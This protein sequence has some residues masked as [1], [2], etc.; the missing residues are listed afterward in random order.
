MKSLMKSGILLAGLISLAG[1][2]TGA[3]IYEIR[4]CKPATQAGTLQYVQA[5]AYTTISE[6]LKAGEDLYFVMRLVRNGINNPHWR[7]VHNDVTWGSPTLDEA[8]YPLQI[9]I[10][11]SGELRWADLVETQFLTPVNPDEPDDGYIYSDFVFK[12][13]TKPGDFA[14]PIK[15]A[16]EDE[17]GN[18]MPAQESGS[19]SKYVF[20][21]LSTKV[22]DQGKWQIRDGN[23]DSAGANDSKFADLVFASN[24]DNVLDQKPWGRRETDFTL[25]KCGFYVQTVDFH[26]EWEIPPTDDSEGVWRTVHE[27]STKIGY[28]T[29]SLVADSAVEEDNITLYVWSTD[30]KAVKISGGTPTTIVTN[31]VAGAGGQLEKQTMTVQ[32]AKVTISRGSTTGGF[33]LYGVAHPNKA[34]LVLSAYPYYT[35]DTNNNRVE[36]YLEVPVMCSEKESASVYLEIDPVEV[37]ADGDLE[38]SKSMVAVYLNQ[39]VDTTIHVTLTPSFNATNGVADADIKWEDYF[40]FASDESVATTPT[41]EESEQA[42]TLEFTANSTA[43]QYVYIYPLKSDEYTRT[44]AKPIRLTPS[45][46]AGEQEASGIKNLNAASF[47]IKAAKPVITGVEHE[48]SVE[49]GAS[50]PL[51]ITLSDIFADITDEENGY[52]LKINGSTLPGKYFYKEEK[53]VAIDD[54]G[55]VTLPSVSYSTS[56]E[57]TGTIQVLSPYGKQWSEIYTFNVTVKDVT[58]IVIQTIDGKDNTYNEGDSVNFQIGFFSGDEQIKLGQDAYAFLYSEDEIDLKQFDE[59]FIITNLQTAAAGTSGIKIGKNVT[60]WVSN[61]ML[62]LDG[63]NIAK[64]GAKFRFQVVL[65]T[66]KSWNPDNKIEGYP[67]SEELN[68]RVYNV[69]PVIRG[70]YVND[71]ADAYED[72]STYPTK[73]PVGMTRRFRPFVD[74]PGEFDLTTTDTNEQFRVQWSVYLD[75]ELYE[76]DPFIIQGN[77][78]GDNPTNFYYTFT[79]AGV[80]TFRC[81]VKDKDMSRYTDQSSSVSVEVLNQPYVMVTGPEGSTAEVDETLLDEND[82]RGARF[83]VSLDYFDNRYAGDV[84]VKLEVV[85]YGEGNRPNPG[86]LL[87]DSAF[88]STEPGEEEG[89]YYVTLS[90]TKKTQV[91]NAIELDGTD[92]AEIFGFEIKASVVTENL[93]PT[94]NEKANDY[95]LPSSHRVYIKNVAPVVSVTPEENTNHWEVAGGAATGHPISW[96]IMSDVMDDFTNKWADGTQGGIKVTFTGCAN[97]FSTNITGAASG[98]FVPNFGAAAGEQSVTLM[99]EDKDGG[100][101]SYTWLFKVTPSKFLITTATGPFGGDSTSQ[102]SQKYALAK[103][104]GKGHTYVSGASFTSAENFQL[105]WNCGKQITMTVYGFGYKDGD[106]DNGALSNGLDQQIDGSGNNTDPTVNIADDS[107][108]K[109]D[110]EGYDSFFY[111]WLAQ[112]KNDNTG[113]GGSTVLNGAILPERPG[114]VS[115]GR[116]TLPTEYTGDGSYLDTHIEAIFAREWRAADNLGD[117]NQDGIPDVFVHRTWGGGKLLELLGLS[118]IENDL[119]DIAA[120]NPDEDLMPGVYMANGTL[121][122][123]DGIMRSYAPIGNVALTTFREIRGLDGLGLN[124]TDL[125]SSD[126]EFSPVET[127]AY[128]ATVHSKTPDEVAEEL[129]KPVDEREA[130]A[131][132]T[133]EDLEKWS[134]EPTGEQSRLDPTKAD[135]DSDGFDDGWEYFFWYAAKV[136]VPGGA[137]KVQ[138]G[139]KYPFERFNHLRLVT[140]DEI[141]ASLVVE[142]FNPCSR[143]VDEAAEKT[144][145]FDNDGL[146]DIEELIIGTNPCHWDTDGDH[147]CDGWEVMMSLDPLAN[148]KNTNEDGDFMAYEHFQRLAYIDPST[149]IMYFDCDNQLVAGEDYK[150]EPVYNDKMEVISNIYY[151]IKADG[152]QLKRAVVSLTTTVDGGNP[153]PLKYGREDDYDPQN[154]TIFGA[155]L[156]YPQERDGILIPAGAP[157]YLDR[158]VFLHDQ[159]YTRYGFDPRTAWYMND[160]GLVGAR[161]EPISDSDIAGMAMRTKEYTTYDEYLLARYRQHFN[162]MYPGM[163][164]PPDPENT[165]GWLGLMTTIPTVTLEEEVT[166][167]EIIDTTGTNVTTNVSSNATTQAGQNQTDNKTDAE[168]SNALA[169]AL[170]AAN[171]G[172]NVVRAHGADSD[173]DGVPDGWELYVYRNPRQ[174]PGDEE[175][176]TA[177]E[178]P[179]LG[180]MLPLDRDDDGLVYAAEF[181]GTDSCNA[182]SGCQSIYSRHPGNTKGWFNKFF[183]TDPNQPDTDRDSIADGQEGND[184]LGEGGVEMRAFIFGTPTDD[185]SRCIRGGGLNPLTVDTDQDALPDPWERQYA[186]SPTDLSTGAPSNTVSIADGVAGK[187]LNVVYLAGGMDGTWYGDTYTDPVEE[188]V[189][190]DQW[191]AHSFDPLLGTVRDV[192]F[193]HDGLEN[194]QEYL[195]QTVRHFR[196]DDCT[197]LLMGRMLKEGP[198]GA[199]H[200]QGFMGYAPMSHSGSGYGVN[201]AAYVY[202]P[203]GVEVVVTTNGIAVTTNELTNVMVTNYVT[204]V[205]SNVSSKATAVLERMNAAGVFSQ[206]WSEM[207]WKFCGYMS[208]PECAWDRSYTEPTL[209]AKEILLP[210]IATPDN[211]SDIYLMPSYLSY[212]STDPRN[213]DTDGDGMDDYYEMFHGLNPLLGSVQAGSKDVIAEA[214]GRAELFNAAF[215]EWTHTDY[216]RSKIF[217]DPPQNGSAV[218]PTPITLPLIYDWMMYPWFAGALEADPDGDGINNYEEMLKANLTSPN[219]THTDPTPRWFTDSGMPMSFTAQYYTQGAPVRNVMFPDS[220]LPFKLTSLATSDE[221]YQNAIMGSMREDPAAPQ[222]AFLTS[223]EENEGY[224]TDND[225]VADGREIIKTVKVATDPLDFSDP[226]RHQAAW[227]DGTDSFMMTRTQAYR[228]SDANDMFKQF[229]VEAW[230]CPERKGIVQTILDRAVLYSGNTAVNPG[231]VIRSNFRLGIDEQGRVFGLFDNADALESGSNEPVSC[232]RVTGQMLELGKWVHIALTYN[233]KKLTLYVNGQIADSAETTLIPANGVV[234]VEQDIGSGL[235]TGLYDF[236][237]TTL[238]LGARPIHTPSLENRGDPLVVDKVS[239]NTIREYFG[240]YIDEVRVWDGARTSAEILG[241][242][243]KRFTMADAKDNRISAYQVWLNRGTRN[244]NDGLPMLPPELLMHYSFTSLPGATDPAW[245]SKTPSGFNKQILDI[246]EV[247]YTKMQDMDFTGCYD[248]ARPELPNLVEVSCNLKGGAYGT[249]KLGEKTALSYGWWNECETK[250]RVYNDITVVPWVENTVAHLPAM[251]SSTMDSLYYS[252]ALAASY[253]DPTD[254]GVERFI[255]PNAANPYSFFNYGADRYLTLFRRNRLVEQMGTKYE[256]ILNLYRYEVRSRL[257]GPSDLLPMGGAYARRAKEM[258]DGVPADAW[259]YTAADDNA[260]GISDWWEEY[261]RGNYGNIT[262]DQDINWN[263]LIIYHGAEMPAY[264]AFLIDLAMGLQ[265]NGQ[266]DSDFVSTADTNANNLPDWW[267]DLFGTKGGADDDDDNDGLSNYNEYL[268]SFGSSPYGIKNGFPILNPLK[269]RTGRD[270][271]VTDYYLS[272]PDHAI[273]LSDRHISP[274]SYIGQIVS[275]TDFVENW[276]EKKYNYSFASSKKYDPDYDKDEDGWSNW[277]EARAF[278][279]RGSFAADVVDRFIDGDN[280]IICYPEPAIGVRLSYNG[281]QDT[282]S[283]GLVVRTFSGYTPRV[284]ATFTVPAYGVARSKIIG[285]YYADNVIR[286]FLTPGNLIPA[287]VRFERASMSAERTYRWH[288]VDGLGERFEYSGTYEEYRRQLLFNPALILDDI[289]LE[290]VEF[291]KTL[292]DADGNKGDIVFAGTDSAGNSVSVNIG[293]INYRTGEYSIDL[294]AVESATGESFEGN[295][296]QVIWSYRIGNEYPQAIWLSEPVS[297]RVKEG[298]NT[299]EAFIDMDGDGVFTPGIDPYGAVHDVEIGWHKTKELIIELKDESSAIARVNVADAQGAGNAAQGATQDEI[300][301]TVVVRRTSINGSTIFNDKTVPVRTLLT[302]TFVNDDRSYI[303]EADVISANTPD[304]D[305]KWLL[306]DAT[307]LGIAVE[308]L[309]TAGYEITKRSILTDGTVTNDVISTFENEFL[310]SRSIA[311]AKEPLATAPVYRAYPTMS[312]QTGDETMKAYRLQIATSTNKTDVIYDSGIKILPG[313]IGYTVGTLVHTVTPEFYWNCAVTTNGSYYVHDASNYYWRVAL[314]NSKF[315]TAEFDSDWSKWT[316]F[317]M[318]VSNVNRYPLLPTGYGKCG[319]VVRYFGCARTN[320]L[321]GAVVVEAFASADFTGMPLD[322]KRYTD[323]SRL[324]SIADITTTDVVLGGIEPGEVYLRA[325]IDLN[326]NGRRDAWEPWGYANRVGTDA[327]DIYT[328]DAIQVTD[329]VNAFEK[330]IIYIEDPDTNRNEIPDCTEAEFFSTSVTAEVVGNDSDGDGLSD[331]DE[332]SFGTDPSMWDSDGDGMPDGW[333]AIFADMDPLFADAGE[334]TDGDVMAFATMDAKLVTIKSNAPDAELVTYIMKTDDTLPV[335]GDLAKGLEVYN[336]FEYPV[337]EDGVEVKYIGRGGLITIDDPAPI[338]NIVDD[339]TN[340]VQYVNRVVNVYDAKVA[341]LHAQ[342]YAEFG[343]N[344]LTAVNATNAVNTK[345]F[346]ALDKYLLLRYFASLGICEEADVNQKNLWKSYSLVPYNVDYDEDGVPDGWELYVMFGKN[347]MNLESF[348]N[349]KA[350]SCWK[351]DDREIDEDADNLKLVNEYDRGNM[352]TDPWNDHTVSSVFNDSD[353]YFY[354][355][356]TPEAQFSDVDNDG[357]SNI[358][359]YKAREYGLVLDVRKLMTDTVT[360]DYFRQ[361]VVAGNTHYIGEVVA[362][363]DFIED[364]IESDFGYNRGLYDAT[365]DTDKDGWSNWSEIR[366]FVETGVSYIAD[367]ISNEVIRS[368]I[369]SEE[370]DYIRNNYAVLEDNIS[371]STSMD[372]AG[373]WTSSISGSIRYLD[374]QTVMRVQSNYAGVPYPTINVKLAYSG[375][376]DIDAGAFVIEA[377]ASANMQKKLCWWVVPQSDYEGSMAHNGYLSMSLKIPQHGYLKEGDIHFAA[378]ADINGDGMYN[379]AEPF[380]IVKSIPVG[381]SRAADFTIELTDV[382]PVVPRI[383]ILAATSDRTVLE[384]STTNTSNVVFGST[385]AAPVA[386]GAT[387][388]TAGG[389]TSSIDGEQ[390]RVRIVR[391]AINGDTTAKKRTLLNRIYTVA[392]RSF[393][394]EGDFYTALKNDID[395][396]LAAD[397][398]S[399][400]LAPSAIADATYEVILGDA[401]YKAG[402]T[403]ENVFATFKN[404]YPSTRSSG[405]PI[406][407]SANSRGVVT[408]ARP[409]FEFNADTQAYTAYALQVSRDENFGDVVF[410]TTNLLSGAVKGVVTAEP[411]FFAEDGATYFW[412]VA[413]FNAKFSSL[414]KLSSQDVVWSEAAKFTVDLSGEATANVKYY[415]PSATAGNIVVEAYS[416]PDFAGIAKSRVVGSSLVDGAASITLSGLPNG[417]YY[418]LAFIDRNGDGVRQSYESWGYACNVGT[419]DAEIWTPVSV[420]INADAVFDPAV[421]TVYIEDTDINQ[422]FIVDVLDN[423]D[424]LKAA[425]EAIS[426]ESDDDS[427]ND[428]SDRDGDGLKGFEEEEIGTD[429][430]SVDT[431]GDGMWDGWEVWAGTDPLDAE[432]ADTVVDGDVMAYSEVVMTTVRTRS[433][434]TGTEEIYVLPEGAA[435]PV[436]GDNMNDKV[437][438]KAFEYAGGMYGIGASVTIPSTAKYILAG[439]SNTTDNVVS[440]YLFTEDAAINVGDNVTGR[441]AYEIA[442]VDGGIYTLGTL[443]NLNVDV[444]IIE[445]TSSNVVSTVTA[446]DVTLGENRAIEVNTEAKV[447]LLHNQVYRKYGFNSKTANGYIASEDRINTKE[448]TALDKY[449]LIRY[450]EAMGLCDERVVNAAA[451]WASWSLKPGII[452]SDWGDSEGRYGDGLPDGWELYTGYSPWDFADRTT[453]DDSDSLPLYN[454]FDRGN[455]PSD[456]NTVD[457]D[458]DGVTDKHAFYYHLKGEDA[459]KDADGDGL[460]NYAEYLVSEVFNFVKLDPNNP[461]TDGSVVDYF[462]KVGEMYLGEMFTD[463]DRVGDDWEYQFAMAGVDGMLYANPGEYD[464]MIDRDNDGWSNYAEFRSN[465]DP[466]VDASSGIDGF[467]R[468][469]HPV[470]VIEMNLVYNGAENLAGSVTFKAWNEKAN[471]DMTKQPDA[472]WTVGNTVEMT[473]STQLGQTTATEVEPSTKYIGINPKVRKTYYL[474]PGVVQA[475]TFRLF[476]KDT[477]FVWVNPETLEATS[478]GLVEEAQWYYFVVDKEGK[479]VTLGGEFGGETEVGT[480]DYKTGKVTIDFA[481]PALNEL[482]LGDPE[483]AEQDENSS[484][485]NNN[486]TDYQSIRLGSAYVK[487]KWQSKSVSANTA[488]TYYLSD[489]DQGYAGIKEGFTTFTAEFTP[490]AGG[491][492]PSAGS[493]MGGIGGMGATATATKTVYGVVRN[494]EVGWQ[495]AKVTIELS[496]H[497][498]ITPRIDLAAGTSDRPDL[499]AEGYYTTDSRINTETNMLVEAA[500]S[501]QSTRVRVARHAINGYPCYKLWALPTI[502]MDKYFTTAARS[503]LTEADFLGNGQFDIDWAKFNAEVMNNKYVAD[504]FNYNALNITNVSY[505]VVIGEGK[506]SFESEDDMEEIAASKFLVTRRFDR[507]CATPQLD[508]VSQ[509]VYGARPTFKWSMPGESVWAKQFGSTYTAFRL[510]I[511]DSSDGLVW[512]SGICRAPQMNSVGQFVW[513]A[514]ICAGEKLANGKTFLTDSSYKWRVSM[515]NAKFSTESTTKWSSYSTFA[516]MVN[517]QQDVNDHGYSAIDVSVK[518]AGSSVVLAKY[519]GAGTNGTVRVQAFTTADFSGTPVAE[520]F[521]TND[522]ENIS[523]NTANAKLKGLPA[524]GDF[525][526]RAFIDMDGDGELSAFE[527]WGYAGEMVV[528]NNELVKSPIVGVWIEDSDTDGDWLP[529]A[530]E[531]ASAGWRGKWESVKEVKSQTSIGSDKVILPEGFVTITNKIASGVFDAAISAGLPGASLTVFQS[532]DF[533]AALIGLDVS[534]MSSISAIR[535]AIEKKIVPDTLKISSMTLDTAGKKVILGVDASV[536]DTIAGIKLRDIFGIES[537]KNY[538]T[539]TLK[540]YTKATLAEA[541]WT[542]KSEIT[543]NIGADEAVVEV[544]L[545][546]TLDC[547]SGYYK[548]EVVQ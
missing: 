449:L 469:E 33:K 381:Y 399:M 62:A 109:Y 461:K 242:Y 308:D 377:Y 374:T 91:I 47:T 405:L 318:D 131:T 358:Q 419:Q 141:P 307:K 291:G 94:P 316:A 49:S 135:T 11:V 349:G 278:I 343:F 39:P 464:P 192:D 103:G 259:E 250:S 54:E 275:D 115:S 158:Y 408:A 36:D 171:Q 17:D 48:D 500:I 300:T 328:P 179:I 96:K 156:C 529:D 384:G 254:S 309:R 181:A 277:A 119:T 64:N 93:L 127:N 360:N 396:Y 367:V 440:S 354:D 457:T 333:E 208:R 441:Q 92:N 263:T 352:P 102:L 410:A 222:Q 429:P 76:E 448:F 473:T 43:R 153:V 65:C 382:T 539:V 409:S 509:I 280:H 60:S 347:D 530:W 496:E 35:Y 10:Y 508:N 304:L 20:N 178:P 456:P 147:M 311:I 257:V 180:L 30:E 380:G 186:G 407:P 111:C 57:K 394:H 301:T 484:D 104:I 406:A 535:D 101:H 295:I 282:S 514:P 85:Q 348:T 453:D 538:A 41:K 518:Y 393:I 189:E 24:V 395:P 163:Q 403:N 206:P 491:N 154:P 13:T 485:R 443:T 362:D 108:Y 95:Y 59:S 129:A 519:K 288:Y 195:I 471:F 363:H 426:S 203:E 174:A 415:G 6:P 465:T 370:Y 285:G 359:E 167:D 266:F 474:G 184:L 247:D 236:M 435:L 293:K 176:R 270:Q 226:E 546:E 271:L 376:K 536:A 486:V 289:V 386:P 140:G 120:S 366:S 224:D 310:A 142:Q 330:K 337:I 157:L 7:L 219:P 436:I 18:Y 34:K 31:I 38:N 61:S 303:T 478:I 388:G 527:P 463:H 82:T 251:D 150:Q 522:V 193:D 160:D 543:V 398:K 245:V 480:I 228:G 545:T 83:T 138:E 190:G 432:D 73:V 423:E 177:F 249:Y 315:N 172:K 329:E 402:Q 346:T 442:S 438:N 397:A 276:W 364:S 19:A 269:N 161:W 100:S 290:W 281:V 296:F 516:T 350:I 476:F 235:L 499:A 323:V 215:N 198:N 139:Q 200:A 510:Q 317:Q 86:K 389:T 451:D 542:L 267:E 444:T 183:P 265:P 28:G 202:G 319:A 134:P 353:A 211:M 77:P 55:N 74:D 503:M 524:N 341:L 46:G 207:G 321:S 165:W 489:P 414:E 533:A 494:V 338:T 123:V 196:W 505:L 506:S 87:L 232:Q 544:P 90:K 69:E 256:P 252:E 515:Y 498:A 8:M 78:S 302:K 145:D 262:W 70:I 416:T 210:P 4:P 162:I 532:A 12:Y 526:V 209:P 460:S 292:S 97:Q 1:V 340:V 331:E 421:A 502:V 44:K 243:R 132:I 261:A 475:G 305:W 79:Q 75:G 204:V 392:N 540:I 417:E 513:T 517:A 450:Y 322:R 166:D 218:R 420:T 264:Q 260:N 71:S 88:A 221:Y 470:P 339:V 375:E 511:T 446:V 378:Y 217:M 427:S 520:T 458:G 501:E 148:S 326:N 493:G 345:V 143:R 365:K 58:T 312:F 214:Y 487:I 40:R 21:R 152:I 279:W 51:T 368:N 130:W 182:Y 468:I 422:N 455:S 433:T 447:V 99:I 283:K 274:N 425:E 373:N 306:K 67:T 22:G 56:G 133:K 45:L 63:A 185:G 327:V 233:G 155:A 66:S 454:E 216:D 286:G 114:A 411:R 512:D 391:T 253:V 244:D 144:F 355:I 128:F 413:L 523:L 472:V 72:G 437:L 344:S 332:A 201:V 126:P 231:A 105:K 320:E 479:L 537:G 32:M 68:F 124:A 164:E 385:P 547:K 199:G 15:L 213:W 379:A 255:F 383:D 541:D 335:G 112:D 528:L 369:S 357:L 53:L 273:L 146:S 401:K 151:V 412:R 52:T 334:Y 400:G 424:D 525:F 98:T 229:T 342:V 168:V 159:I 117:I 241:N 507:I 284:D 404:E 113:A 3:D 9:G 27:A 107:C 116:V 26:P 212:V 173:G 227:F 462:R 223:F 272:G 477:G 390:I 548:V 531:Y 5:D 418:L 238:Y 42:L 466:D 84:K 497:S 194:W 434:L 430:D 294:A 240:G 287:E 481:N 220:E 205:T 234:F 246:T 488:G 175:T 197:T 110:G 230:I 467:I 299:V 188:Q 258:W 268:I 14:L 121:Q 504:A 16:V 225:W 313:R 495:G 237:P 521:A 490:S 361:V 89:V 324:S 125:T 106:I 2:A 314:L 298:K 325:Y 80:Y 169:D 445:P 482:W 122:R 336:S 191:T 137:Y 29:A 25:K 118:S 459:R 371:V 351:F 439:I 37:T 170:A 492:A 372:A 483:M 23:N 248:V 149:G 534:K 356:K 187:T 239:Y 387:A 428:T 452:D 431:D 297:G 81:K 50:L 136:L